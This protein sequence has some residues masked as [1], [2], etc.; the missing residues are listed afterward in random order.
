MAD[1]NT[2]VA[3]ASVGVVLSLITD[4][5]NLNNPNIPANKKRNPAD[6]AIAGVMFVVICAVVASFNE[7]FGLALAGLFLV[8]RL[9]TQSDPVLKLLNAMV[10]STAKAS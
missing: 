10:T 6:A 4:V 5:A 9:L 7:D 8:A 2:V 1:T 3:I